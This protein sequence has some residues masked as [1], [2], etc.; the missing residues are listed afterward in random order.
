MTIQTCPTVHTESFNWPEEGIVIDKFIPVDGSNLDELCKGSN[1]V[2]SDYFAGCTPGTL[3]ISLD[4]AVYD[5]TWHLMYR[6]LY[7]ADGWNGAFI[8]GHHHRMIR[9]YK[10]ISFANDLNLPDAYAVVD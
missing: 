5:Q 4:Y 7:K 8:D 1:C 9:L 3:R 10:S 2:N 6:L